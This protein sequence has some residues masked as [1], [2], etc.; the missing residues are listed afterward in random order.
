MLKKFIIIILIFAMSGAALAFDFAL[1]DEFN[2]N[3]I[4]W[5]SVN[6]HVKNLDAS[7][8]QAKF[9]VWL[10]KIYKANNKILEINLVTG[11]GG[12]NYSAGNAQGKAVM[13]VDSEYRELKING[14]KAIYE[15][16]NFLPDVL[17]IELNN[18]AV[19]NLE[20]YTDNLNELIEIAEQLLELINCRV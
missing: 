19:L 13:P 6:T 17:A 9:G 20:L 18:N 16:N 11:Q 10:N 12:L 15:R 7:Y 8:S 3:N 2:V 5:R 4:T 14:L 1:P